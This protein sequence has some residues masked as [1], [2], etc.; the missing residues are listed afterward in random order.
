MDFAA[1]QSCPPAQIVIVDVSDDWEDSAKEA[2][3]ILE[4]YP[5]IALDYV[6]SSVRSSATQRNEGISLCRH[7]LVFL[8]DDDSF[9]YEDCAEKVLQI[10]AADQTEE[11]AAVAITMV[12]D[13]PPEPDNSG[14]DKLESLEKKASGRNRAGELYRWIMATGF[15]RWFNRKVLL[16]SKEELFIKYD[17]SRMRDTPNSVAKFDVV[18]VAFMSG[19]ATAVRRSIAKAEPFDSALRYYAA[20]EDLDVAYRYAQHGAVL[21][22]NEARLHHYEAAGGRL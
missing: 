15:G 22:S 7:D 4:D 6:T 13:L 19:C 2:G 14:F 12:P 9:L 3:H 17:G 18:P 16:Q 8:L 20:F 11:I 1:R 5:A 10:F 21:K